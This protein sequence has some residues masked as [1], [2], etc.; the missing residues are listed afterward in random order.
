MKISKK[1]LNK[2]WV[3]YKTKKM[4]AEFCLRPFPFSNMKLSNDGTVELMS[5][6]WAQVNYCVTDWKGVDG[7]DDNP[8]ECTEEN[9]LLIFNYNLLV[10]SFIIDEIA[11]FATAIDKELKN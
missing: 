3:I 5:N 10:R 6:L 9:K 8:L 2:K 11:K 7:D 4:T 1:V